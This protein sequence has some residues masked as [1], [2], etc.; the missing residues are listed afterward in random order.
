MYN[1]AEHNK[2]SIKEMS[3]AQEEGE[4]SAYNENPTHLSATVSLRY[5]E[6]GT[7]Q[8]NVWGL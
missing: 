2:F 6:T 5:N 4:A 1:M 7:Q 8:G 3:R